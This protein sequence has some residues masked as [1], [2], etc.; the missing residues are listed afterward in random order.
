MSSVRIARV[1]DAP[2]T[3]EPFEPRST[4]DPTVVAVGRTVISLIGS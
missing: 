3:R 1:G 2:R 4:A